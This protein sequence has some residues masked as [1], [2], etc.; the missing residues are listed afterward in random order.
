M[1]VLIRLF[2]DL[3]RFKKGPQDVPSST[4]LLMLL[5]STN[6]LLETLL[7]LSVYSILPSFMLAGLS[8]ATLFAFTWFWLMMFK[9]NSRFL[10]TATAFMGVS[11]FT[12][13]IVFVPVLFLWKA[14]VLSDDSYA[15]LNLVLIFWVLSIYA[16]IYRHALNISFFLGF[17]LAITYFITFNTVSISLLGV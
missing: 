15:M 12:N 9:M 13:I 8:A 2:G 10:Q 17:A 6:F 11:L 14:E 4:N 5:F 16:H 7:G 3:C 1:E